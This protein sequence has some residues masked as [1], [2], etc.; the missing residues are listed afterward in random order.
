M[1]KKI[2]FIQKELNKRNRNAGDEDGLMGKDTRAAMGTVIGLPEKWTDNRKVIGCIQLLGMQQGLEVNPF[3]GYWGAQ[4]D[5]VFESLQELEEKGEL[6]ENWRD[7]E[8]INTR[9]AT[10]PNPQQ[11][12]LESELERYYGAVGQNQTRIQLPYK[13]VIAWDTSQAIT[14]FSCHEKVADSLLRVLNRVLSHYGEEKIKA[15]GL[16]MFGG[17]LNVRKIRGGNRY[18]THSWG[19]SIDYNPAQN[20]LRWGKDKAQFAKPEY[21][22]WWKCW[23]DEGWISLGRLK[24]YDWMHVQAARR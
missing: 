2:E 24:D 4:T 16:D 6:P 8:D 7:D 14:S 12:P 1:K 21:D 9:E 20:K 3:D 10:T 17:C 23:E 5:H 11:W 19:I 13:H 15:L 18:S 22:M